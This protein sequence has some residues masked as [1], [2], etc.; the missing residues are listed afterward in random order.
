MAEKITYEELT[1]KVKELSKELESSKHEITALKGSEN[2][3]RA[4]F[5][6]GMDGV[7]VLDPDTAQPINFNDQ[8]CRQLGYSREEFAR[9]RLSDIEEKE[10]AEEAQIHIQKIVKKGFDNFETLQRT[11]NGEIR[12]V[13]VLAQVI[14]I[15]GRQVYHCIWRDIT[16]YRQATEALHESEQKYRRLAENSPD[17]M[18]RMSLPD[19]KYEY[20]S[21]AA[22]SVFGYPP[23]AWYDNPFLLRKI[24]HPDWHSYFEKQWENLLKGHVPPTYEYKII[25]KDESIRWINQRNILVKDD[26]GRSVAIEGVATDITERNRTE[27]ALKESEEKFRSAFAS[28]GIGMALVDI[29]G[30]FV[31]VNDKIIDMLGYSEQEILNKKFMEVT[32][33]DDLAE[34]LAISKGLLSGEYETFEIQKRYIHKNGHTIWGTTNLSTIKDKEGKHLYS[35]AQLQDTTER[36]RSEE[37]LRESEERYRDIFDNLMDV[38]FK[39]TLNGTIENASPSAKT[40]SGY[41]PAELIGKKVDIL[42][43]NPKDREGLLAVLKQKGQARGYE[44]LF[45]KKNEELY[46]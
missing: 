2:Y 38:Y 8:A 30:K 35:I 36:K 9:L 32:H 18:Y 14:D 28:S 6:H 37:S 46:C 12:H 23:E 20:V 4:F 19:G 22:A 25:H 42:Y 45:K 13:Q 43:H 10:T 44:I 41:S 16:N 31:T 15:D 1:Q 29:K 26:K 39:T 21:P 7:V 40:I 11:K 17:M 27:E 3:Y 33:P 24:I 34:S 5:E